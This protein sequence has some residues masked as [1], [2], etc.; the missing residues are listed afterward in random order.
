MVWVKRLKTIEEPNIVDGQRHIT[1][2]PTHPRDFK[3][4]HVLSR[5]LCFFF[6]LQKKKIISHYFNAYTLMEAYI[7]I[8]QLLVE[9]CKDNVQNI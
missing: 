2:K 5:N 9:Q 4:W 1:I 7:H 3:T 8:I 6:H